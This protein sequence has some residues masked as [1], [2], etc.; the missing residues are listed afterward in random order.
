MQYLSSPDLAISK[1]FWCFAIECAAH[2]TNL[3][4]CRETKKIPEL[5]FFGKEYYNVDNLVTFG[6]I[7]VAH[8][9]EE[10]RPNKHTLD[11]G[12]YVRMLGYDKRDGTYLVMNRS[13]R[14]YR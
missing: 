5:D 8:I 7:G 12:E 14:L 13:G 1:H 9:D 3:T 2:L 11:R 4:Y 10:R 6:C